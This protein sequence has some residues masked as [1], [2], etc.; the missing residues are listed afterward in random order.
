MPQMRK[1][2]SGGQDG[3]TAPDGSSGATGGKEAEHKEI[4][5][6]ECSLT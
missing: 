3:A 6:R 1:G 2:V 5:D 4:G